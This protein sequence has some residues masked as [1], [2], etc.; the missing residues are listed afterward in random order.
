MELPEQQ[1]D[2]Q[3]TVKFF[4]GEIADARGNTIDTYQQYADIW[5]EHD[6]KYIQLLF[7]IDT[8]T[9]FNRHAPLANEFTVAAFAADPALKAGHLKSL[10]RL[11]AY[12]GMRRED[13]QV[14]AAGEIIPKNCPWLKWHDHNQL[15]LTRIMRSI[16]LLTDRALAYAIRDFILHH[17]RHYESGEVRAITLS[18]WANFDQN[19]T[20][21]H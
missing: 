3:L 20:M 5:L 7:P 10:D 19:E 6:H 12:Y 17:A 14:F 4:R 2:A 21:E 1:R 9:R 16:W 11:L 13:S 15:R 8:G 18:H